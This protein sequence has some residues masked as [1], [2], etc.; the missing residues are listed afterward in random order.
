MSVEEKRTGG[1]ICGQ[2]YLVLLESTWDATR[3]EWT[4]N[5]GEIL[6]NATVAHPIWDGPFSCSGSGRCHHETI[7]YCPRCETKPDFQGAPIDLTNRRALL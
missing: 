6:M 7:P 3:Q 1:Q 2:Q 5:C 4:H